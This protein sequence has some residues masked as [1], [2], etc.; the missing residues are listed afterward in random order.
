VEDVVE[1][2]SV[3]AEFG[4][5]DWLDVLHLSADG[6]VRCCCAAPPGSS[7]LGW[8]EDPFPLLRLRLEGLDRGGCGSDWLLLDS[9]TR[10]SGSCIPPCELD[11]RAFATLRGELAT[12]GVR[13]LDAMVFDDRGHWWSL[14][15]R[16]TGS[17]AWERG[18]A[19]DP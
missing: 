14:L 17:S 12:I 1:W 10:R 2:A 8:A 3:D 13:L 19:G 18:S 4:S 15:E 7:L 16:T 5:V 6:E 9:R 11:D